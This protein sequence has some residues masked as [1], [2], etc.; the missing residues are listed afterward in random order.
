MSNIV[1]K[2]RV[3]EQSSDNQSGGGGSSVYT[4]SSP[5]TVTVGGLPSGS[6]ISGLSFTS[7]LQSILVPYIAPTFGSFSISQINVIEVGTTI[8][9][10]KLFNWSTNNASNIQSNSISIT[11][12][13]S[14]T[15]LG[16]GL[17]N[18]GN[19]NLN[20][21]SIT[22]IVPSS[23]SWR[24]SA[25]N[26]QSNVF[27]SSN[28]TVY[29]YY[30]IFYGTSALLNLNASQIQGLSNSP[31][32]AGFGGTFSFGLGNYKYFCYPNSFGS[33]TTGTGF[34]DASNNFAVAMADVNDDTFYSN[35][36]NGWSYGLVSVTNGLGIT[37]SYRVYRTKNSLSGSINIIIS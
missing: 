22:N 27:Y 24:A 23:N 9:G 21:G 7:I 30:R 17:I 20:I 13:T 12:L 16:S 10:N 14:S 32:S 11:D 34:K 2:K 18:D 35:T 33:P 5:T 8:S 6:N 15:V 36:Q 37:A 1:R 19:E 31:L 26:T 4:G 25:I 3:F 29:W 28:D